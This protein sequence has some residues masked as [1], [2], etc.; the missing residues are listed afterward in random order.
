MGPSVQLTEGGAQR[1]FGSRARQ[2]TPEQAKA[3]VATAASPAGS[4]CMLTALR[5]TLSSDPNPPRID[6]SGLAGTG[7]TAAV[8]D[9]GAVLAFAGTL[10]R[11]DDMVQVGVDTVVFSKGPVVVYL[12]AT[13]LEGPGVSAQALELARKIAA[14]LP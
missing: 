4:A 2:G 1:Q 13:T 3:F 10:T 9:G 8:A 11:G 6:A 5:V 14:R 7:R 12:S